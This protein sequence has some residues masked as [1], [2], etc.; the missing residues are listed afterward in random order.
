M[1]KKSRRLAS[2]R[3]ALFYLKQAYYLGKILE[4]FGLQ[5]DAVDLL[6]MVTK[7]EELSKKISVSES[8]EFPPSTPKRNSA[9]FT[10]DL[11]QQVKGNSINLSNLNKAYNNTSGTPQNFSKLKKHPSSLKNRSSVIMRNSN[12]Q[13]EGNARKSI[14]GFSDTVEIR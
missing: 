6:E 2:Q 7:E 10:W 14:V 12:C 11:T 3:Q 13:N 9:Q 1:A 5:A 8:F 4:D